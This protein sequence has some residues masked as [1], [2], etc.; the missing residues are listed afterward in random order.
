MRIN[1][2]ALI[3]N[4]GYPSL[5]KECGV[6]YPE[7]VKSPKE[8]ADMMRSLFSIDYKLEEEF[9]VIC[10]NTKGKVHGIMSVAKGGYDFCMIDMKSLFTRVLL[11]G[12][13]KIIICHN[14]PSGDCTP[15]SQDMAL[16]ERVKQ[17]AALLEIDLLDHVI[18]SNKDYY[19]FK[20]RGHALS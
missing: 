20:E 2:Y 17:A 7:A 11:L 8:I 9:W 10:L 15:S 5:I 16:T 1:Q 4:A 6:N 18:V 12:A 14:H 3:N 19:S 13:S